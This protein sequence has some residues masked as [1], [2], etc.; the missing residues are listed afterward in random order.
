MDEQ[1]LLIE[2]YKLLIA[3]SDKLTERR[4][5]IN[6]FFLSV[7]SGILLISGFLI[8]HNQITESA[9]FIF[10]VTLSGLGIFCSLIWILNLISIKN[11]NAAKFTVIFKIEENLP[12]KAYLEEWRALKNKSCFHKQ[13]ELTRVELIIPILFGVLFL[14]YLLFKSYSYIY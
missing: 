5:K 1:S 11:I 8:E 4:I 7:I 12:I 2:Q 9:Q 6:Q 10:G 3:Q 14:L 13:L